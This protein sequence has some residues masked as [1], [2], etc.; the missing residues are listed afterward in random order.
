MALLGPVVVVAEIP[1]T[2]FIDVLAKAGAFPIA[3]TRWADVPAAIG[4]TQPV[5]LAIADRQTIPSSRQVDAAIECIETRGG[6]VMPVIALVDSSSTP[7]IPGALPIAIDDSAERVIARLHSALRIRTLHAA[8]LRRSLAAGAKKPVAAFVPPNLLEE[9]TVLCVARGGSYPALS[10]PIARR[11]SLMGAL[12]IDTAARYLNAR[13]VDGVVVGDGLGPGVVEALLILLADNP[14]FRDLP[15][16]VLNNAAADDE[17]L[18][19]LVH[20]DAD[21]ARLVERILPFVR[22]HA[23]ESQLARALKALESEG[24][25]DPDTGLF[26]AQAFWRNLERAVR[27]SEKTNSALSVARF[28]FEGLADRRAHVDAA[29]LFSRLVRNTDFA[30]REQDGSILAA[31]TKTDLRSAHLLARRIGGVLRQTMLSPGGDRRAIKP[32]ITLAALKPRDDLGTLV[33]RLGAHTK[34]AAE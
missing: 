22:L 27:E 31:F 6:P 33:A 34:V 24:A 14:R 10:L 23:F 4:E 20:V 13:D 8:V 16:G 2:D 1:A 18:P 7:A 11:A 9:S 25:I 29:R 32:T 26:A 28:T 30:C 12:S 5:A 19:N 21:P 3:Q 15:I 17:R